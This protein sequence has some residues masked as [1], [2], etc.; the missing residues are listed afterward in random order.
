MTVTSVH[1]P[2]SPMREDLSTVHERFMQLRDELTAE[3][4]EAEE[5]VTG[6]LIA[7]V[8]GQHMAMIGAPGVAKTYLVDRLV[9]R[10]TGVN[11]YAE[12]MKKMMPTEEVLGPVSIQGLKEDRWH[13]VSTGMLPEA[14]VALIDEFTR[15][16][17]AV[18][19]SML[20][21]LNERR[22]KNGAVKG[23]VP[24]STAFLCANSFPTGESEHDLEAFWDRVV[25]RFEVEAPRDPATWKAIARMRHVDHPTPVLSWE[26]VLVAK[27]AALA[28]PFTDDAYDA[29][30]EIRRELADAGITMSPRRCRQA[31]YVAA[32]FAWLEAADEVR[33]EHC[34]QLVHMLWD[35]PEQRREVTRRVYSVVAPGISDALEL[36]DGVQE[37]I[38]ELDNVLALDPSEWTSQLN[39][40][41]AKTGS[42]KAQLDEFLR[43]ATGKAAELAQAASR[44]L[45]GCQVRLM[46]D[47][48]KIDL[49]DVAGLT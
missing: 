34:A 6:A 20:E 13:R 2:L 26:D 15:T 3:V 35:V 11:Y 33:P 36:S 22:Y 46:K 12:G 39:E 21:M 4:L 27:A 24:L 38:D 41:H 49:A 47:G 43:T 7:L 16:S 37:L 23:P 40:L 19:N 25:M 48:Y 14:D 9:G 18:L 8:A 44:Q 29:I 17:D 5:R 32:A 45:V 28:L 31:Q 10:I 42:Q 30:D 1:R